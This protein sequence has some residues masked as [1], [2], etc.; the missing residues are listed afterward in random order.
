MDKHFAAL[1][2]TPWAAAQFF[3]LPEFTQRQLILER[4][5]HGVF[6]IK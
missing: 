2:L 3:A 5:V 4:D 1:N 6:I